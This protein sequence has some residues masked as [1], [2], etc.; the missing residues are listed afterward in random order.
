MTLG[1]LSAP[2]PVTADTSDADLVKA[3]RDAICRAL[4][5]LGLTEEGRGMSL[6]SDEADCGF[7]LGERHIEVTIM[8][9]SAEEPELPEAAQ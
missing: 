9:G 3:A 5:D 2:P 1:P 7:L 4:V 6:V 8:L